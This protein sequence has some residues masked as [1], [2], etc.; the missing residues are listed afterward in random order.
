MSFYN[1]YD[2]IAYESDPT[3]S[4]SFKIFREI[5]SS[6][7]LDMVLFNSG[8]SFLFKCRYHTILPDKPR[9]YTSRLCPL[10]VMRYFINSEIF[11]FDYSRFCNRFNP[12]KIFLTEFMCGFYLGNI[13]AT[14]EYIFLKSKAPDIPLIALNT[15]T[16]DFRSRYYFILSRGI[17]AGLTWGF[18]FSLSSCLYHEI[19][20]ELILKKLG[21]SFLANI[22]AALVSFPLY[23]LSIHIPSFKRTL[24]NISLRDMIEDVKTLFRKRPP[25]LQSGMLY[26]IEHIFLGT[27]YL[28]WVDVLHLI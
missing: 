8:A 9:L 27:I 19:S 23:F 10:Y 28:T 11:A 7:L 26:M 17:H 4:L 15:R 2:S 12:A 25:Y 18:Y 24:E 6:S 3:E 21:I 14:I 20:C 22:V 13:I 16:I 5:H 1:L